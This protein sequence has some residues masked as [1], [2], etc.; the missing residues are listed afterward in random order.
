MPRLLSQKTSKFGVNLMV[1]ENWSPGKNMYM[2]TEEADNR[3]IAH[4]MDM[5]KKGLNI[6]TICA[7]TADSD[8]IFILTSYMTIF[9]AESQAVGALG[10]FWNGKSQKVDFHKRNI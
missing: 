5:L 1:I 7:R 6:Q 3:L 2:R 4:V 8:F 9:K 10:E